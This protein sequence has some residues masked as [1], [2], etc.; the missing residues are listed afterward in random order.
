MKQICIP[1]DVSAKADS[2]ACL[3]LGGVLRQPGGLH[4]V[5]VRSRDIHA[6][7]Q[8]RRCL[9][10]FSGVR[11]QTNPETKAVIL[12]WRGVG[13]RVHSNPG[14]LDIAALAQASRREHK[15]NALSEVQL[16]ASSALQE[17]GGVVQCAPSAETQQC[18]RR[19]PGVKQTR[20]HFEVD[21]SLENDTDF[22]RAHA[23]HSE[24]LDTLKRRECV[25]RRGT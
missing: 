18:P 23:D 5:Q 21:Q 1:T 9:S 12:T 6:P 14:T 25:E 17:G 4:L 16:H 10:H 20:Q 13:R 7:P 22:V 11:L 19:D 8:R 15:N 2:V 24:S 3:H